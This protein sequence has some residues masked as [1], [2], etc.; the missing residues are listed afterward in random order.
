MLLAYFTIL[1][2]KPVSRDIV[3]NENGPRADVLN[4]ALL[5]YAFSDGVSLGREFLKKFPY[6]VHKTP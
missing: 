3:V 4:S 1:G 6:W 5:A 2:G